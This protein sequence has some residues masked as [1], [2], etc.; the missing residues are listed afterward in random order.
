MYL[1]T[2]LDYEE[3]MTY[4]LVVMA[5]D[6]SSDSNDVEVTVS[7]KVE[8]VNDNVP[9]VIVNTLTQSKDA[10][11]QEDSDIG[12]SSQVQK[13]AL[14]SVYDIQIDHTMIAH[15]YSISGRVYFS[16]LFLLIYK[17]KRLDYHCLD[18]SFVI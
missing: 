7:V 18:M 4:D 13:V 17:I 16:P 5:R 10:R 1:K 8:D 6:G 2:A 9:K 11:I 12:K 14:K 15:C 3:R